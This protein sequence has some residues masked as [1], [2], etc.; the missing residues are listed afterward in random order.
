MFN[1]N[2]KGQELSLNTIVVA[3]LILL[4]LGL[5]IYIYWRSTGTVFGQLGQ[6]VNATV[7]MVQ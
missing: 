2:K 4:V 5:L 3:V 7:S 1:V 6:Q